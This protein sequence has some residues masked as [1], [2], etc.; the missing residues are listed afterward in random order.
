VTTAEHKHR[1]EEKGKGQEL[2]PITT[3]KTEADNHNQPPP[4]VE[5]KRISTVG[6]V[7]ALSISFSK[8]HPRRKDSVDKPLNPDDNSTSPTRKV[9][10]W[11]LSRFPRPRAKTTGTAPVEE[12]DPKEN[13]KSFIGGVALARLQ[14]NNSSTPSITGA[15]RGKGKEKEDE[16]LCPDSSMREMA[17]AGR[18]AGT[19]NDEPGE[20]STAAAAAAHFTFPK[21][22][23][24]TTPPP[25]GTQQPPQTP[26]NQ[27]PIS[28][29]SQV[30]QASIPASGAS[31]HQS[32]SS[33]SSSIGVGTSDDDRFVEARSEPETSGSLASSRLTPPP[34]SR[35]MRNSAGVMGGRVSPFRESRFSEIL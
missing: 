15:D 11:L 28:Q 2:P 31:L 4:D 5:N 27:R 32:V 21:I 13:R 16:N 30:S 17:L 34:P 3:G 18:A 6:R 10:A 26:P 7:R 14:G 35:G 24:S 9:R 20:S 29:V 33:M 1:A 22:I 25:Q 23:P 19:N 8:R 12:H